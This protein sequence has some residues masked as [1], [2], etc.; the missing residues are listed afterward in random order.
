MADQVRRMATH[1]AS[2]SLPRGSKIAIFAKNCSEWIIADFAIW[3][4]GHVSVPLYAN[5]SSKALGFVLEHSEA[6]VLFLGNVEHW[7][8]Q[9]EGI[10]ENMPVIAFPVS[11]S[12]EHTKW[13]DVIAQTEPQVELGAPHL[14]TLA[15]IIYTSRDNRRTQRGNA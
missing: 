4:S 5:V 7:D 14:S 9:K 2:K 3:A 11:P 1:L 8:E 13:V 12:Q 6:K 15:T 10:P